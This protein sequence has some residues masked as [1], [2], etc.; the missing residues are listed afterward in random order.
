MAVK[1]VT[2]FFAAKLCHYLLDSVTHC[3]VARKANDL[4][5][6]KMYLN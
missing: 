4:A 1:S 6:L 2:H 3:D 5:I